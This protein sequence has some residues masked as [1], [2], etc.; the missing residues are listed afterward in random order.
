MAAAAARSENKW[1]D[2]LMGNSMCIE[3]SG[4]GAPVDNRWHVPSAGMAVGESQLATFGA[5]CYWGTEKYFA[6]DFAKAHPGAIMKTRVG[7]MSPSDDARKNPSY[8]EV[9]SGRTGHVEVLQLS[10]NP[11]KVSYEEIC[12]FFFTF[13][14]PTTK[15]R[16]GN[17]V[18]SQYASVVFAHT[19][20]QKRIANKTIALVQKYIDSGDLKGRF[21]NSKV[22]TVVHDAT[23]FYPAHS[24][25]QRYLEANPN[26]Y[27][28]HRRRFR[29][30]SLPGME[31]NGSS[32]GV[33]SSDNNGVAG[34]NTV[35][36]H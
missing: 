4:T 19:E 9:C 29:W 35:A 17:D 8:Q 15:N 21:S 20:E 2:W 34:A 18:G 36:A 27:C 14:D 11:N 1:L 32:N 31:M 30:E 16:Q 3:G 28:N 24:A 22:T 5:G 6:K 25:H 23:K 26:G 12:K 13:H 7:F 10:Y 33:A